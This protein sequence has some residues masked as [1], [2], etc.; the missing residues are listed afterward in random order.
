MANENPPRS[1][2]GTSKDHPQAIRR[3]SADRGYTPPAS[4]RIP[5]AAETS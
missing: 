1:V 5:S 2:P 3:H 4:A